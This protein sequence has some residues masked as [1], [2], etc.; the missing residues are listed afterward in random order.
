MYLEIG[1]TFTEFCEGEG[2][3]KTYIVLEKETDGLYPTIQCTHCDKGR[4][5]FLIR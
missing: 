1:K 4:G 3:T 2:V 5:Y